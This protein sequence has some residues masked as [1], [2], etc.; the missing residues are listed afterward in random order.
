[1]T[2]KII[3]PGL[4]ATGMAAT[5]PLAG[6][7]YCGVNLAGT[8]VGTAS[9]FITYDGTNYK[10]VTLMPYPS[11]TGVQTTTAN[12]S[13]FLPLFGGYGPSMALQVVFTTRTSGTMNV[14]LCGSDDGSFADAYV[15]PSA[16][17]QTQV[18][19]ANA[20]NTL[21]VAANVN[22]AWRIRS[23]TVSVTGSGTPTGTIQIK[24]GT[25]LVW[26][27]DLLG[28]A[29]VPQIV[30]L[31]LPAES[32]QEPGGVTGTTGNSISVVV[33]ALG[34]NVTSSINF[35]CHAA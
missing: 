3:R 12:G 13:W 22:H 27:Q 35:E 20:T 23:C 5:I 16:I 26:S 24:D 21:T 9:F 14:T 6:L 28:T 31:D 18:G 30:Q 34:A 8:W 4:N 10:P 7:S 1:M 11:G 17:Y 2:Q 32:T 15:A 29:G 25:T 19:T 33:A